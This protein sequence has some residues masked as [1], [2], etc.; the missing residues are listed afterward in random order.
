MGAKQV[1]GLGLALAKAEF[2]LR[3]EGS[4]L[5]ILW[6]LLNPVLMFTL[7]LLVFFDRLGKEISH[8]PLYLLLGIIMFNLFQKI[9]IESIKVIRDHDLIIKSINFPIKSLIVSTILKTLFSHLFEITVFMVFLLYFKIQLTYILFYLLLLIFFGLFCYGISLFLSS[10]TVYFTDLQNVWQFAVT[11]LWFATPIFYSIG[12]QIRLQFF[13]YFNP[14]FYFITIARDV[15][16][17]NELPHLWM[18]AVLFLFTIFSLL[19]GT[20]VFNKLKSKFA[21]LI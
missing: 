9:T 15:I 7:L 6:Y 14:L 4:Y 8:Y 5:G 10:L 1:I 18:F 21:E 17:Y 13:S 16:I 19:I 3:N 20:L 11:L 12:G 2:K